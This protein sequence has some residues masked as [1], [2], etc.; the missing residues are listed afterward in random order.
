MKHDEEE[1]K[2]LLLTSDEDL[3]FELGES[4]NGEGFGLSDGV[5]N[6][7]TILSS[8]KDWFIEF[9]ITTRLQVCTEL[10]NDTLKSNDNKVQIVCVIADALVN[11]YGKV[12][13]PILTLATLI[14]KEGVSNFCDGL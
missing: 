8:A 6:K 4:I 14:F 1:I 3:F 11:I 7:K 13:F 9:K 10:N 5:R 12:N 2:K